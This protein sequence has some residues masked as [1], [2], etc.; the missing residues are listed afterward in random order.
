MDIVNQRL[1]AIRDLATSLI[2]LASELCGA[3][4]EG[5]ILSTIAGEIVRSAEE[6]E[7]ERSAAARAELH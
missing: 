6:A 2:L 3:G 1:A 7:R 4:T 5:N